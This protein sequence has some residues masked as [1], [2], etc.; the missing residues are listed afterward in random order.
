MFFIPNTKRIHILVFCSK[1]S[2]FQFSIDYKY[3]NTRALQK[4]MNQ[5]ETFLKISKRRILV[6]IHYTFLRITV[7][8]QGFWIGLEKFLYMWGCFKLIFSSLYFVLSWCIMALIFLYMNPSSIHQQNS[9]T[10]QKRKGVILYITIRKCITPDR[11]TLLSP[12]N[13]Y[14]EK[15]RKFSPR[16]SCSLKRLSEVWGMG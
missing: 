4:I 5:G 12:K 8:V 15:W 16:K 11:K 10:F 7:L 14:L 3:Q 6:Q 1:F 9:Y 13:M 2:R